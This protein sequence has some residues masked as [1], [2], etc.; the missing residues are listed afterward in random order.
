MEN[1]RKGIAMVFKSVKI[2]QIE[3]IQCT[4]RQ[5]NTA[6][7][8][9]PNLQIACDVKFEPKEQ[10]KKNAKACSIDENN[11]QKNTK[12]LTN[13]TRTPVTVPT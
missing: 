12:Y 2:E 9:R 5:T 13:K 7:T 6:T 3:I 1:G 4:N 10:T 11:H 8:P